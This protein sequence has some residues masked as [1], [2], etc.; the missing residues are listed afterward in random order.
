VSRRVRRQEHLRRQ[1]ETFFHP[2]N[3][4]GGPP[5]R[6][7]PL[8]APRDGRAHVPPQAVD[9]ATLGSH[10]IAGALLRQ[11]LWPPRK[12]R[13]IT[14]MYIHGA[15]SSF[16]D[17]AWAQLRVSD[18]VLL[19]SRHISRAHTGAL[20]AS[21]VCGCVP[22]DYPRVRCASAVFSCALSQAMYSKSMDAVNAADVCLRQLAHLHPDVVLPKLVESVGRGLQRAPR[23]R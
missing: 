6:W 9:A 21:S 2:S 23:R 17:P 20:H 18:R 5:P 13:R 14:T 15:R 16:S 10:R 7:Q 4:G 22:G 1:T 8:A 3:P 19:R 12:A 11:A